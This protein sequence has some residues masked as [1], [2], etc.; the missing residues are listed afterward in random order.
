MKV[1]IL[2]EHEIDTDIIE[3]G[4]DYRSFCGDDCKYFRSFLEGIRKCTLFGVHLD[5]PPNQEYTDRCDECLKHT[6][7]VRRY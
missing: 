6:P 7:D 4:R 5:T 1:E 3:E 2:V